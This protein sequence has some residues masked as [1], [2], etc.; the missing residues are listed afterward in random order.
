MSAAPTVW[1]TPTLVW[2]G[3]FAS[4]IG[5]DHPKPGDMLWTKPGSIGWWNQLR[6]FFTWSLA[7]APSIHDL[8]TAVSCWLVPF[9]GSSRSVRQKG[10][11]S[12]D[13]AI[14]H[15][16]IATC[17]WQNIE[18]GPWEKKSFSAR[19]VKRPRSGKKQ[20]YYI[21]MYIYIYIYLNSKNEKK[22]LLC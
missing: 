2:D 20:W 4:A 22:M 12:E 16:V 18:N 15:E 11:K 5:G 21:C 8:E 1:A 13:V 3:S 6:S 19:V 17:S 9:S 7:S 10:G 14:V